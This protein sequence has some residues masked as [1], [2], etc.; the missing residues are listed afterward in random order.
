VLNNTPGEAR[1]VTRAQIAVEDGFTPRS[2]LGELGDLVASVSRH[3]ILQPLLVRPGDNGT[4]VLVD[5]HRRLAAAAQAGLEQVPVLVRED[6]NDNA[7]VAALATALK[8]RW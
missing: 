1:T 3:G 2:G 5:G 6:L 7:L 4:F 8:H